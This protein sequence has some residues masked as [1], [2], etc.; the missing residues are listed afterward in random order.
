MSVSIPINSLTDEQ[1]DSITN[2]LTIRIEPSQYALNQPPTFLYPFDTENKNVFIPF[3]YAVEK[4]FERLPLSNFP[5][6]EIEFKGHLRKNQKIV[7]S[8]VIRHFNDHGCSLISAYCGFGKTVLGTYLA[9]KIPVKRLII[10]HR[11]ILINQW[12]NAFNKF[13]P[14][15]GVQIITPKTS[16]LRMDCDV[17]IMN[18]INIPKMSKEFFKDIGMVIVDEVHR[19]VS[20]TLSRCF[21]KVTPR[22]LLALSATPYRKDGMNALISLYFGS[23]NIFRPLNREHLVYKVQ[24]TFKPEN[25]LA[26]NGRIDWSKLL[27]SQSDSVER[28]EMIVRIAMYFV[29]RTFLIVC[30]RVEQAR[31]IYNRLKEENESVSSL[32]GTEQEFDT[33]S[34]ILVSSAQKI[35]E[36]FDH[37]DLDALILGSDIEDYFIQ[38]LGR[39][40]RTEDV[41]PIIFDI[42]D[43]NRIL[44]KHF[45]TREITYLKCGGKIKDFNKKFPEIELC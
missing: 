2:D 21:L 37:K 5:K 3:S 9:C 11:I 34:R 43:D 42:I 16:A 29:K 19:I 31:Y 14:K 12:K 39:V 18:A 28:N 20:T 6:S 26:K 36:G 7:K 24:T 10:T 27:N 15:A 17:F 33:E 32:I 45:E 1:K 4:G 35:A 13:V 8:E 38:V 25:I 22:Y 30:K 44:Y 40:C 41:V 23:W